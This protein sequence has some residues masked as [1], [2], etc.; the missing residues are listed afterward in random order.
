MCTQNQS[1][2]ACYTMQYLNEYTNN[3]KNFHVLISL[4][5]TVANAVVLFNFVPQEILV[6]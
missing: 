2:L 1:K 6:H 5:F 3:I 4:C